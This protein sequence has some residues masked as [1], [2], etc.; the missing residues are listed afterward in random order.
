MQQSRYFSGG[1]ELGIDDEHD[2]EPSFGLGGAGYEAIV[3]QS[4][5][6]VV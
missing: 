6:G 4:F 2:G 3:L 1:V 5:A